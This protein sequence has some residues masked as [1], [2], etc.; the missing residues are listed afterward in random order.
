MPAARRAWASVSS[1]K[2]RLP[3]SSLRKAGGRQLDQE[4]LIA[5]GRIGAVIEVIGEGQLVA[6]PGMGRQD[7]VALADRER[8]LD[9]Q[10]LAGP[11]LL[12]DAGLRRSASTKARL[13]PS[14][15][16][17]SA[18]S[19]STRQLSIRDPASAAITCS[20]I[21][22]CAAPA[23]DGGPALRGH[24][25][26]DLGGDRGP[27]RQV[28]ADEDDPA[29]GLGRIEA[30][31]DVVTVEET[32]PTHFR[33][34]GKRALRTLGGEHSLTFPLRGRPS[35]LTADGR[36]PERETATMDFDSHRVSGAGSA[37]GPRHR[38]VER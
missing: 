17:H 15:P 10:G 30:N 3:A 36:G 24:D 18:A 26:A 19:I 7:R 20:I 14:Q 31:G 28:G 22:T 35:R 29:V 37:A 21:S 8:P 32:D 5:D 25:V 11:V 12:D 34:A 9:D 6:E 33:R 16:G 38:N 27:I 4:A 13:E 23:L 1:R 2:V